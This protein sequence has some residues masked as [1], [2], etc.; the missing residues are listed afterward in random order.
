MSEAG[1]ENFIF[2]QPH[3]SL[4]A[5]IFTLHITPSQ[6]SVL[7]SLDSAPDQLAPFSAKIDLKLESEWRMIEELWWILWANGFP[8]IQEVP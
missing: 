4:S 2:H 8:N 5:L 7:A 3:S 1:G 6:C